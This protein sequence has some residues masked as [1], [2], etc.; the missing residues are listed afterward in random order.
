LK[1]V[2]AFGEKEKVKLIEV[3]VLEERRRNN[4]ER[5]GLRKKL[6]YLE[7]KIREKEGELGNERERWEKMVGR[8]EEG[9]RR[10]EGL[11]KE[12][13]IERRRNENL[14]GEIKEVKDNERERNLKM[15]ELQQKLQ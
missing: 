4:V 7:G 2:Q 8:E 12:V 13:D 10:V 1:E 3:K 9:R 14:L 6:A 5:E 15:V 11:E